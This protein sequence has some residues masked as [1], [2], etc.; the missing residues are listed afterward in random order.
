MGERDPRI[1]GN[2]DG[3]GHA[4][5]DLEWDARLPEDLS[6]LAAAAEDERVAA[7]EAGHDVPPPGLLDEAPV[8]LLLGEGVIG[9][10]FAGVDPAGLLSGMEED[11]RADQMVIEDHIRLP[12]AL[13]PA[14]GDQPRIARPGADDINLAFLPH[15]S[16]PQ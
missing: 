13:R 9:P 10:L 12:D 5:D 7:F 15:E 3:G 8:D 2:G 16:L 4:G 11:L 6:L 14:E 1:G